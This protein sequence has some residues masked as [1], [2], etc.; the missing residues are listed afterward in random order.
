[1]DHHSLF[2]LWAR[3]NGTRFDHVAY[4]LPD[5]DDVFVGGQRM[6]ADGWQSHDGPGRQG[7]GSHIYWHFENP[8][9]GTTEYFT[10]MD[11]FDDSWEPRIS[12]TPAGRGLWKLDTA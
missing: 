12:E 1:M 10:D 8:A 9:G 6:K 7:H 11:R 4:E 3:K 5:F 2:L